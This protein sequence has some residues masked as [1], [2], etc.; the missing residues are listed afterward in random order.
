MEAQMGERIKLLRERK[1]AEDA[2]K[3]AGAE[4]E[5]AGANGRKR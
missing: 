1:A 5:P 4:A 3:A 2:A